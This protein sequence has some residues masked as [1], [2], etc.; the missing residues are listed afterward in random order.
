[1]IY[2]K[3]QTKKQKKLKIKGKIVT[4]NNFLKYIIRYE[5]GE[6]PLND[7]I[8][9]FSYLISTGL[10]YNLQGTYGRVA[11]SLIMYGYIDEEG[12]ILKYGRTCY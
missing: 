4:K 1:M 2:M 10:C 12:C 8:D 7:T 9:L 5:D 3:K 6:L 11:N